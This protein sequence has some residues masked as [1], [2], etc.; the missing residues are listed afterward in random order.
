MNKH[1]RPDG[2][3]N[4]PLR[5]TGHPARRALAA[6]GAGPDAAP[7]PG[8]GRARARPHLMEKLA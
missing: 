1:R 8:G 3:D 2:V 5:A 6:S 7:R 4:I